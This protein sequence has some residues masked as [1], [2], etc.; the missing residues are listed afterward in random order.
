MTTE[1]SA[2]PR[3]VLRDVSDESRNKATEFKNQGND[4][5]KQKDFDKAI[6]YYTKAIEADPTNAILYSNRAQVL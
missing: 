6:E 4:F 3:E 2:P 1:V 5:F